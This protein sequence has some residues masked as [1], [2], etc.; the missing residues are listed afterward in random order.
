LKYLKL[1]HFLISEVTTLD[2]LF[3]PALMPKRKKE[4]PRGAASRPEATKNGKE[5]L[6]RT[7]EIVEAANLSTK[8]MAQRPDRRAMKQKN[9][10]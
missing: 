2:F 9:S 4:E 3:H 8:A 10:K 7:E 5:E 6:L 1:H